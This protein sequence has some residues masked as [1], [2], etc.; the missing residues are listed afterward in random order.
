LLGRAIR[1]TALGTTFE[2]TEIRQA[3]ATTSTA[4][5]LLQTEAAG[6]PAPG[7]SARDV[8]DDMLRRLP[9]SEYVT[10]LEVQIEQALEAAG[11]AGDAGQK[12]RVLLAVAALSAMSVDFE[13]LYN[14]IFGGQIKIL[15]ALNANAL[16]TGRL[17]PFYEAAAAEHPEFFATYRFEQYLGFL[18][19]QELILEQPDGNTAITIKGRAFLVYL[20]HE[21]KS[22]ERPG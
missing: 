11:V 12:S 9:R 10:S 5:S 22:L 19:R 13:R 6:V 20:A 8:A 4:A 3:E 17:A 1:F 21:G 18:T 14:L 7:R 15:Q 2:A 16:P